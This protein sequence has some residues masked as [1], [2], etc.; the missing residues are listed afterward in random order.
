LEDL[1]RF[2][3]NLHRERGRPAA[4]IRALPL[5][6]P[7]LGELGLPPGVEALAALHHGLVLIGGPTGSGKT[8]T[9]AALVDLINRRQARHIVTIEDPIE[10]EHPH[11]QSV[12]EQ[13]EI[14][15]DAPDFATA[16]R[17][18]VRQSPDVIVVG[19]MRD[20]ETMRM[21]LAASETGH[22][23]F[24]TV[25]TGDVVSTVSRVSDAFP[26]E[27][28][29]TIRQELSMALAAVMTQTL[30]PRPN[31]GRIAAAELLMVGYG[32]RQHIRKNALQHLQQE[33][34]ITRKEGSF[35]LE[36]CMAQLVKK[37]ML[38]AEDARERAVH[39]DELDK[40]LRP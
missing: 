10:F 7:Q 40:L 8:T 23:V 19:E 14:G 5:K 9:V 17:A 12:V 34:T 6:P 3:V 39:R 31:G 37:G 4:S 29:P 32:A 26:A 2:R 27:R 1:G 20:P 28:Q 35:T 30:L 38:A 11:R 18:A 33:I 15:I 13:V 36:E 16:L 21:A 25:H 22:L 24:S